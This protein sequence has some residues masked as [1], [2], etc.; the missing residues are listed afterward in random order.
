MASISQ[1]TPPESFD[2]DQRQWLTRRF[3]D[4]GNALKQSY[5]NASRKEMPYKPQIGDVH[6]FPDPAGHTFDVAITSEG[7]WGL[8]STGWVQLA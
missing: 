5:K 6:F 2:V 1:E 7:W 3:V 8:K 4:V